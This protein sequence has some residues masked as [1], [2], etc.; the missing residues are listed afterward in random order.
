MI[1]KKVFLIPLYLLLTAFFIPQGSIAG[2]YTVSGIVTDAE[3]GQILAGATVFIPEFQYGVIT[4]S[5]GYFKLSIPAG[6]YIIVF[7]FL[8]YDSHEKTIV[9]G[10]DITMDVS[11]TSAS[12]SLNEV[13]VSAQAASSNIERSGMGM[14]NVSIETINKIP[15]FLGETDV[16]RAVQLLPGVQWAG[17]GNTGFF[18]RGG[19]A[20]QNL[21]LFD[22][23]VVYNSSH[24]FNFFSVFNPDAVEDLKLYKGGISPSYGGRLSSVLDISMRSGNMERY[25]INGGIGIISSRLSVEGPVRK[26]RSSFMLAGR[27]TYA[28]M[29]LRLSPDENRRNTRLYFYDLNIKVNYV[30]DEKNRIFLSGYHGRDHTAFS[31]MFGFDWGNS[32]GSLRWNR[33]FT[34]RFS[35]NFSILLSNYQFNITG[36][37]GPA[38]FNWQSFINNINLKTDFSF[39]YNDN[40]TLSFGINSILH[41]LDPGTISAGIE[42]AY[43]TEKELPAGNALEHGVYLNNEQGFFDNLLLLT[44][45]ARGSVFQVTGP[46]KQFIYNKTDPTHWEVINSFPLERGKIYDVFYGFEPRVSLRL[47]LGANSSFKTSYNRMIQYVQQAQSAQSV[48][49]YDVWYMSSNNIPPQVADQVAAGYFRNFLSDRVEASIEVYYKDLGNISDVIDNGD[50]LGNELLESQL[51]IGDGWSYG[52]EFLIRK[53]E[54]RFTGIAGYTWTRTRRKI[55]EINDGKPYYA[56]ND[57]KHDFSLYGGYTVSGALSMSLNFIFSSGR[58]VTLPVGK[59]YYQGAFA[60]I[61]SGRNSGRLP[62]Y[63]RLDMSFTLTPGRGEGNRRFTSTWNFS[64][65]NIYGRINPISVSF[66]E[67][68]DSP[69]IPRSSFFYIPG[70]IPGITWN[71]NF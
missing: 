20:D 24:L 42:E 19:E 33:M 52:A 13:V 28:D 46:G 49:P 26:G 36:D 68:S 43:A 11:L 35:G 30:L 31:D 62:D 41:M 15:S 32:T 65:F 40:S 66:A 61:Y 57:R 56:P 3:T 48:A 37:I 21:V 2:E 64:L 34:S 60:P 55:D 54:G 6:E 12:F 14:M 29:F 59:L 23:A 44:Y 39:L 4:D 25:E 5:A 8:G 10:S 9:S 50:I 1:G 47:S 16:L 17:D 70:P 7:S 51:R 45:G 69:G 63:H 67:S 71:F 53:D 38:S 58:A 27:R 18:V 22:D